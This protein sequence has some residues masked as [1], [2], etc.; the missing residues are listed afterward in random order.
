MSN[1]NKTY[2][3]LEQESLIC[4]RCGYCRG[5][6]PV[7]RAIGW[8]S[9]SPRGK[10]SIAR[11]VFSLKDQQK[12]DD[13]FVH[14]VTQCTLCGACAQACSTDI[15]LRRLYMDLR[16]RIAGMGLA[17]KGYTALQANL[18]A[19][20]NITN[21]ANQDRLDWA[22]DVDDPEQLEPRAGAEV[23]YF[24]GCVSS[25]FPQASEVALSVTEILTEAKVDFTTLGGD[26]WCCGFPLLASGRPDEAREFMQHN[27][28]RI[29]ALD[30]HT[31]IASCP[32][33]YHVW[34][35]GAP[36][37]LDGYKLEILHSTEYLI[38][39]IKEGRL[40]L[41]EMEARITYHDPCDL[42][43][44]GGVFDAPRA[45]IQAIEGVELVELAH[46]RMQSL[47]CGGGGNL[48]SVDA[49]LAGAITAM[50][51]EEI[52]AT[53]AQIVVSA[54]QQCEQMLSAAIRKAGLKVKVMDISQ[55]ILEV[56][57]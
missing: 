49:E 34:H 46:N 57:G 23:C 33:C 29:K 45:I 12:L 55:L 43:R 4:A 9:A 3:T 54:C 21:F 14:R 8:E 52:K 2:N 47:C 1:H 22:Q 56:L 36:E 53:G 32:S 25:F 13:E 40:T 17:P 26:E 42:G 5:V 39:L 18:A 28:E 50:R 10:L 37:F 41:G 7:Y 15:D 38:R 44:N 6:C 16:E 20:R 11:Q 30:I 27:V 24:V 19:N 48:Q 31:F 51:V 35:Q